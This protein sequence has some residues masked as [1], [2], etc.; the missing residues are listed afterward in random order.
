MD[1]PCTIKGNEC[2]HNMNFPLS[3]LIVCIA[4]VSQLLYHFMVNYYGEKLL[5]INT[6]TN[7]N[8]SKSVCKCNKIQILCIWPKSGQKL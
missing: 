1:F 8:T 2:Y 5:C 4:I 6:N 3:W 7:I